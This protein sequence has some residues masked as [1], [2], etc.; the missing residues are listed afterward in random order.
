MYEISINLCVEEYF[1][2]DECF[3]GGECTGREFLQD[4]QADI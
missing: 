4:N 1:Y 2:V 3:Y